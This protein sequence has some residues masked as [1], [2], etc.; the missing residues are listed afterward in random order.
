R[1]LPASIAPHKSRLVVDTRCSM[2]SIRLPLRARIRPCLRIVIQDKSVVGPRPR[3]PY[4]DAPPP[5][6][7]WPEHRIRRLAN[8]YRKLLLIWRPNCKFMHRSPQPPHPHA[9]EVLP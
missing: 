2:D 5:A 9:P 8:L 4:G 6:L 3:L 7:I 1:R